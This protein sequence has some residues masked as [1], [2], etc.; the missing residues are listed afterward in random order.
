[1]SRC[2]D[3]PRPSRSTAAQ[4]RPPRRGSRPSRRGRRRARTVLA[5]GSLE[6]LPVFAGNRLPG[7][8]GHR[9]PPTI[10][11]SATASGAWP[12][13]IVATQPQCR[14]SPGAPAQRCRCRGQAGRRHPPQSAIALRRFRQGRRAHPGRR[15]IA[16]PRRCRSPATE[17]GLRS[18]FAVAID[19]TPRMLTLDTDQL[20][21]GRPAGSPTSR[22]GCGRRRRRIG[23]AQGQ[24]RLAAGT[25]SRMWRLAGAAAGYRSISACLASGRAAGGAAVRQARRRLSPTRRS[26]RCSKRPTPPTSSPRAMAGAAAYPRSRRQPDRRPCRTRSPC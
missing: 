5:T 12:A 2:W 8:V 13:A 16:G 4:C 21:V 15:P 20:I 6:R 14:L 23:T 18:A 17:P 1:M 7:V 22:S 26:T 3:L 25:K 19:E 10:A 24:A 9:S 11:P